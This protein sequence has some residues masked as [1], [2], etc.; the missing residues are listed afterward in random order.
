[1]QRY[2]MRLLVV[3]VLLLAMPVVGLAQLKVY[4]SFPSGTAANAYITGQLVTEV[5]EVNGLQVTIPTHNSSVPATQ[6]AWNTGWTSK[7]IGRA[8]V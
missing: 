3:L 6:G 8:H 4:D 7:K 5:K 1:M 2:L